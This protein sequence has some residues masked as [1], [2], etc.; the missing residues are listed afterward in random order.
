MKEQIKNKKVNQNNVM[1]NYRLSTQ[2]GI[3]VLVKDQHLQAYIHA[4]A[5]VIMTLSCG[6]YF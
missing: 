3:G 5:T 1:Y 2:H 6:Y 4:A